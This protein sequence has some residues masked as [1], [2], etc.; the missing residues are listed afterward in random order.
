MWLPPLSFELDGVG[1]FVNFFFLMNLLTSLLRGDVLE[2]VLD[3]FLEKDSL[4]SA[5]LVLASTALKAT[6]GLPAALEAARLQS[7]KNEPEPETVPEPEP[8]FR[9]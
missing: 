4:A 1:A 9:V 8:G 2:N 7:K 6:F 3:S 5:E